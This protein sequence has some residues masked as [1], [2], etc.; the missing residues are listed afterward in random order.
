MIEF[1]EG[2]GSA[3]VWPF[4]A[5]VLAW[6]GLAGGAAAVLG[7]MRGLHPV[8]GY[9]LRQGL[10][11]S[12]PVSVV[13]APWVP[14]LLPAAP[15][16]L[17]PALSATGAVTA[18]SVAGGV[19]LAADP[20]RGSDIALV[21]LGAATVSIVL[22]AMTRLVVLGADLRR[23]NR[24]REAAARVADPAA[25]HRLLE[26][27]ERIGVR[28]PVEL[29]EGP[30]GCAPMTFGAWRPVIVIPRALLDSPGSLD[31]ALA[32]ELLHIRR[33]DHSWALLDGLVSAVFAFHPLAWLLRRG[34]ERCRETSC[35]AEVISRGL[36]RP[37]FYAALLAHAHTPAQFPMPAVAASLAAPSLKLRERLETMKKFEHGS[38]TPRQR[39]GIV[40]GAGALC[41]FV[42]IAGA[43]ADRTGGEP[44]GAVEPSDDAVVTE[45][46]DALSESDLAE[47]ERQVVHQ[48]ALQA[49]AEKVVE[50]TRAELSALRRDAEELRVREEL[51]RAMRAE[52]PRR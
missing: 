46:A 1:L 4:W 28:R 18:P 2:I 36:V 42:A 30:T 45:S 49:T 15:A 3:S 17:G 33:A 47:R 22:L 6:T 23:L 12:L 37:E 26:L 9:R 27:A 44:G 48:R 31:A 7:R 34:I 41:L 32:H 5:P 35:D 8:A 51:V 13:A 38:L 16:P 43:C 19:A 50:A 10:L 29:L 40:L 39:L 25:R 52:R 11:L 21:L 20:G 14:G 24:L